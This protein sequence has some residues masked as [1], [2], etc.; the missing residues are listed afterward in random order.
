MLTSMG[1]PSKVKI[2]GHLDHLELVKSAWVFIAELIHPNTR[3]TN[4]DSRTW[5][6]N[7]W[8]SI[9]KHHHHPLKVLNLCRDFAREAITSM[10]I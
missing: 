5:Y 4:H 8:V 6:D 3:T 7:L 10:T 9:N 1:G 2:A